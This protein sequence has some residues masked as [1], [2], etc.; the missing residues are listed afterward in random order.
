MATYGKKKR[1]ILS[2]FS[3]LRDP[4]SEFESKSKSK[5]DKSNQRGSMAFSTAAF[6]DSNYKKESP[7]NQH[8]D[9]IEELASILL[10]DTNIDQLRPESGKRMSQTAATNAIPGYPRTDSQDGKNPPQLLRLVFNDDDAWAMRMAPVVTAAGSSN[11]VDFTEEST[12]PTSFLNRMS[13]HT[14][15][16]SAPKIPRKSSKR[17]SG[18]P[19]ST[20]P[21]TMSG[22]RRSI[23]NP[24]GQTITTTVSFSYQSGSSQSKS[25]GNVATDINSKVE[26]MIAATKAL[27]PGSDGIVLPGPLVPDKKNRLVGNK[28]LTKMKTAINDRFGGRYAR[29][30]DSIINGRLLDPTLNEVQDLEDDVSASGETATAMELRMNE[31][32]NFKNPKIFNLTGHGNI[33]R[34]PLA[35]D[36]KSLR[37]HKSND[38]PDDPFSERP[39]SSS[40]TRTPTRFENRLRD[41]SSNSQSSEVIPDLPNNCHTPKRTSERKI[42]TSIYDNDFDAMLSSSPFAQST[43]RIRLEP[44]FEEDG[45]KVLKNVSADSRSLFDSDQMDL[46]FIRKSPSSLEPAKRKSSTAK[47]YGIRYYSYKKVKKHPSPSKA[48]LEGLERALQAFLPLSPSE[49]FPPLDDLYP[50]KEAMVPAPA[51]ATT[52]PNKK[53]Q[54]T[55]RHGMKLDSLKGSESMPALSHPNLHLPFPRQNTG[56]MD[57]THRFMSHKNLA[58][59]MDIEIDELQWDDSTYNIGMRRA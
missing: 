31:G 18:R 4:D 38:H 26:A 39:E 13:V 43:P 1:S 10:D 25:T 19:Q 35:D 23:A 24:S 47:D 59:K 40:I 16:S 41:D 11:Q 46:D 48:E 58:H 15:K 17:R 9:S 45:T 27:K 36:G 28:V 14:G 5:K 29:K 7:S 52:D 8:D 22:D 42:R 37:S 51:L 2:S 32:D 44:T 49:S 33:R 34:K 30:R 21:Q 54:N 20:Q 3:V 53:M 6:Q 50:V 57:G 55:K 12:L 56:G